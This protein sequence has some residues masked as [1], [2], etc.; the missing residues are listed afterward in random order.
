MS[1][2]HLQR[3]FKR[4]VGVTPHQYAAA[5]RIERFK[6]QLQEGAT[7]TAALYEA[8]YGSASGVYGPGAAPLGMAPARY[9]RG[10]EAVEIAFTTAPCALG[11]LLVAATAVGICAIKLGDDEAALEAM[12]RAE[13]PA[14][15]IRRDDGRLAPW[16]GAILAHLAGA[17]PHLDL[18]LDVRATAFQRQVWEALQAVPYGRTS[19]YGEVAAAIGRPQAARAVAQACAAN[20]AA[21]AIPCH[22]VVRA[23]G[24]LGGY[25]WGVER[26]RAL[27]EREGTHT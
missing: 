2:W 18:P 23:D 9:R 10:G 11:V 13:L 12:L 24:G 6:G 5:Q 16:L 21:I 27:L 22:R 4:I 26:K 7:V 19:T 17:Q 15:T 25:R 1:P 14:A 20:P 3:T 8:G